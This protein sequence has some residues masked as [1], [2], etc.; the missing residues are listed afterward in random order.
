MILSL[1][2]NTSVFEAN[3]DMTVF[4]NYIVL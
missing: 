2:R 1:K 3:V 4:L